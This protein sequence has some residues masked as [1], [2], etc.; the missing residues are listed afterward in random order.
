GAGIEGS[1]GDG[2]TH[3]SAAAIAQ[4]PHRIDVLV[5]GS[6]AHQYMALGKHVAAHASAHR[7][8]PPTPASAAT[9]SSG[10]S[11]RPS[12]TSPQ[13]CPPA[14]GPSIRTPRLPSSAMLAWVAGCAH[15]RRFIAGATTNGAA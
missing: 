10:S 9:I 3:A 1:R 11:M 8:Q 7:A 15:I 14:A 2:E 13:A 12:P 4:E 6:G 5:G